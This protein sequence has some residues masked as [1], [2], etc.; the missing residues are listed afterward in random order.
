MYNPEEQDAP[1]QFLICKYFCEFCP[2]IEKGLDIRKDVNISSNLP[3][4][5]TF[6]RKMRQSLNELRIL[7]E[8]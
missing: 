8:E 1:C 4:W 3:L 6:P 7:K 2:E 5:N